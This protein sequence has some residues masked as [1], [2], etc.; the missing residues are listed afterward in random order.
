MLIEK[1]NDLIDIENLKKEKIEEI[2]KDNQDV[3]NKDILKQFIENHKGN[4]LK[5][6]KDS[7]LKSCSLGANNENNDKNDLNKVKV[8][9]NNV[10]YEENSPL[11]SANNS[12]KNIIDISQKS[13]SLFKK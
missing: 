4:I 2:Y 11:S 13:P 10:K 1:N 9:L 6:L 8:N 3:F 12:T 7:F 5:S